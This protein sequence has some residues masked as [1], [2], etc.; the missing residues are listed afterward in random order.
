M[1]SYVM[2]FSRRSNLGHMGEGLA[3]LVKYVKTW[4]ASVPFGNLCLIKNTTFSILMPLLVFYPTMIF[5]LKIHKL[6][7]L[8]VM[9][10]VFH[11]GV[12]N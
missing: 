2:V 1:S 5:A 3:C 7:T 6:L 10:S 4:A 12:Q 8:L 11:S 9:P